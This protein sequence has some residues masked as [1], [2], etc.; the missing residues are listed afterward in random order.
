MK[1]WWKYFSCPHDVYCAWPEYKSNFVSEPRC[2]FHETNSDVNWIRFLIWP[3]PTPGFRADTLDKQE[4]DPGAGIIYLG[5]GL[6]LRSHQPIR[7]GQRRGE[8]IRGEYCDW[9]FFV[10]YHPGVIQKKDAAG[11]LISW[12]QTMFPI[13]GYLITFIL[14]GQDTLN[15]RSSQSQGSSILRVHSLCVYVNPA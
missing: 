10:I 4:S 6:R 8:P 12:L 5:S 15:H 1:W 14:D 7:G 11:R 13:N 3:H 9:R 2:E